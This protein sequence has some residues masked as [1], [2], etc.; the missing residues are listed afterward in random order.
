MNAALHLEQLKIKRL[1]GQD[2]KSGIKIKLGLPKHTDAV[3]VA[4]PPLDDLDVLPK[5]VDVEVIEPPTTEV[6]TKIEDVRDKRKIDRNLILARIQGKRKKPSIREEK[7]VEPVLEKTNELV[8]EEPMTEVDVVPED[9]DDQDEL[10]RINPKT[11]SDVVIIKDK[12]VVLKRKKPVQEEVKAV[13]EIKAK[14]AKKLV[15]ETRPGWQQLMKMKIG[16]HN[17][18]DRLPKD[19]KTWDKII[20]KASPFYMNNRKLFITQMNRLLGKYKTEIDKN[21]ETATCEISEYNSFGLLTHQK[22]VRDYMNL[23]TPYRG[24]LLF[25]GLG[26]GKTCTS[27]AIAEGMKSNKRVYIMTPASLKMNFFSQM[28]KCGDD[29]YRK[30]QFWEFVST[31]GKPDYVGVL[32][33]ALN[34][35]A[36][37]VQRNRGAWLVNVKKPSNFNELSSQDQERIDDQINA[38]I[39]SKYIDI[40]YNGLNREKVRL[41]TG[42]YSHNPFDNSVVLIDEAHN[43]VSRIIN[44]IPKS[45]KKGA[46]ERSIAELPI[47]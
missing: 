32:T 39:R 33:A 10:F 21:Q 29:L 41:L 17:I 6:K 7:D 9:Q 4:V 43:F 2:V 12:Q 27:I 22:I 11:V 8:Q 24:L 47:S 20:M 34:L 19:V 40:N 16:S 30:N 38:M 26:S 46:K 44:K 25:H 14:R 35:P 15:L 18:S 45:S 3:A 37:Y 23:Y 5:E 31:E 1:P 13:P 28:K 36:E 42:D